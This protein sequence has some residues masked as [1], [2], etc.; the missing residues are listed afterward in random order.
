MSL[1]TLLKPG[2][3]VEQKW[4]TPQQKRN[5]K[6]MSSINWIIEYLEDRAWNKTEP[7]KVKIKG[8]GSRVGVFRSGT[9]T[10]KSTVFPPAI[11]NKFFEERGIK[12]T[13]ICTQP[14]VATATDIPYQIALYN[15]NLILG[16]T[17]GYQTGNLVRKPRT[18]VLFA[19]VGILLQH[20][21]LLT[22]EEF[23]K[24]YS[25]IILDEIHLRSVEVDTTLFYLR[26]FLERNYEEPEC[27]YIIL[28][29]GTFE[30]DVFMNY[31]ECPK[32]SF[33]DIVGS[34]FPIEDNF[35]KFNVT[36]YIE[37]ATDLAE[38]IHVENIADIKEN[39]LF[40]D[41]LIFVQG[42]GQIKEIMNKIHVLNSEVFSKGIEFAKKH[43]DEQ[44]K[45]YKGGAA[46]DE[47][48]I[49][50]I[51]VTSDNMQRG[52][53]DY[54][55][56]F[57]DISTVTVPIYEIK[58]GTPTEKI[59]KIERASRRVIIGTNAIET[60]L[61]IDTLKYC[62]DTGKVNESQFNPNF[63]VN[64][65]ISKNVTQAN[66]RQRRGRVGRKDPGVF[67]GCY[68][69]DTYEAMPKLPFP[70]IVKTDMTSAL[71]DIII[72]ETETK[73]IEIDRNEHEKYNNAFQMNQ[74]DQRWYIL[75]TDKELNASSLNFIQYPASDSIIYGL[76]KLRVLGFIDCEYKP[77]LFGYYASKF[78]KITL[79]NARMILAGYFHG[80]NI[81]DL[82]TITCFLQAGHKLGIKRRKYIPRNP[83][84]FKSHDEIN[85]YYSMIFCDEFIEYL[86][87]W[88][89]FM[90]QIDIVTDKIKKFISKNTKKGAGVDDEDASDTENNKYTEGE[91]NTED[92]NNP[93]PTEG[94]YNTEDTNSTN[95]TTNKKD[96]LDADDLFLN[97]DTDKIKPELPEIMN[98]LE[99]WALENK[100]DYETLMKI[101]SVRDELIS[102]L[103]NLGLNPF[104]NSL[105]LTRGKYKLT[106][107]LKYNLTDG[108]EEIK[109]IKNCIYEGYRLNLFIWND[110]S[111]KYISNVYNYSISIDS[112][113]IR[114]LQPDADI[115][116]LR[117]QK[118]VVANIMLSSSNFVKGMYEFKGNDISIL[119]GYVNVDT[120]FVNS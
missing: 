18:G 99:K 19:T 90:E 72:S 25:F 116:Q 1:P 57:A 43:S 76:E 28:T 60:G 69:K 67:Y 12:K 17:I 9:G 62:I 10:G 38:K 68:T 107:I 84:K 63:G 50:P 20:L 61:T 106:N 54:Q 22:D 4:M 6:N 44:Q 53:E 65:L 23:M 91:Y 94:E 66:S 52:A 80:A 51:S 110:I 64:T 103:L 87:I 42:G 27:P 48:Y 46:S 95:G 75:Q 34:S 55:N 100:F 112:K 118:I 96:E 109:K 45:K 29:S 39:K 2:S 41:I 81:L 56:L 3:I 70:D 114:P 36:N 111:Q 85:Y 86:F 82:I 16:N 101:I 88:E 24:K 30:P 117:P 59:I 58:N 102:D 31:F 97:E 105:G 40:R 78:R 49:C 93:E 98:H 35:T 113:L 89:D 74:F 104:Y 7:P 79:E 108:I 73:I 8:P 77:T 92:T 37:Y 119:D 21:K 15:K 71:L 83:L 33:L 47:Y 13:I 14:T 115:K 11:Y 32:D 5:L 26:R 120:N